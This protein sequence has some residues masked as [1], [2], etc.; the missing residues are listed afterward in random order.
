M[1]DSHTCWFSS[2]RLLAVVEIDVTQ[3]EPPDQKAYIE[4]LQAVGQSLVV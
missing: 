2:L 3:V 4:S 1:K